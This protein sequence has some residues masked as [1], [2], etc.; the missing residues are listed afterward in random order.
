[1]MGLAPFEHLLADGVGSR[2]WIGAAEGGP[3]GPCPFCQAPM[4]RPDGDAEAPAGLEVC[5]TCQQIWVP[6]AAGPWL[7]AHAAPPAG[8]SGSGPDAA[9][10][11]AAPSECSNCGGPYQPDEDGR[12]HWC[13]AQI[14]APQPIVMLVDSPPPERSFRLY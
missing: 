10:V 11:M 7:T 4:H 13:Q 9:S 2:V 5:R 6:A 12:C 1:M 3:A 8:G 14:G